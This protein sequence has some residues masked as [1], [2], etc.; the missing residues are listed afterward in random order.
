[1]NIL[2]V[3]EK[4][5]STTNDLLCRILN[6]LT[7]YTKENKSMPEYVKLSKKDLKR[8][9]DYNKTIVDEENKILGMKVITY[10]YRDDNRKYNRSYKSRRYDN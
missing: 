1:M 6:Y 8:I 7:S 5:G 9:I 4:E 10:D 2:F 3:K